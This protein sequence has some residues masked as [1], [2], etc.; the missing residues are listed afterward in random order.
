MLDAV[1]EELL[2]A[3]ADGP[4]PPDPD[5]H[6][7]LVAAL[8]AATAPPGGS[9]ATAPSD[10][11]PW[12]FTHAPDA[13]HPRLR[14]VVVHRGDP[15]WLLEVD[16]GEALRVPCGD[17]RWPDAAGSPYVASG[18]WVGPGVFEATVVAVETPHS[19]LLRCADGEVTAHWRGL[20]LHG[21]VLARLRAPRD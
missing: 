2:P 15:D 16:D 10:P 8:D 13:E 18:G 19:L 17:G 4:L 1:W 21:P 20:P 3:L 7:R 9:T 6:A 11:G 14:S 5:A 12:A